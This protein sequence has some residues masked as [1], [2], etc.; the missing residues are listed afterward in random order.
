MTAWSSAART[1]LLGGA[2]LVAAALVWPVQ[3]RIDGLFHRSGTV[4]D[5]LYF[6][7]PAAVKRLALGY[8]SLLADIYWMRAIQYYGRRDEAAR[9][10]VRYANLMSLLEITT[11]LDPARI[12]AYRF[13]GTFLA[14]P[15]PLGAGRPEQAAELLTRG[16]AHH[17]TEWRLYFDKGFIHFWYLH[18]YQRAGEIWLEGSRQPNA[19]HWMEGLAAMALQRSGAVETARALWERQYQSSEQP[20]SQHAGRRAALDAGVPGRALP[21]PHR[22]PAPVPPGAGPPRLS[23]VRA[24]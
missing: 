18:E 13:G 12:D 4:V 24:N 11:T 2:C 15:E 20:P 6:G 1:W 8:E 10:P 5:V 17:P 22:D 9:R 16:I 7:S 14:E 21:P 23:K 19:P 3:D